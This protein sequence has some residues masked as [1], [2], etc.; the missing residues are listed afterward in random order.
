MSLIEQD[1]LSILM[2]EDDAHDE[3]LVVSTLAREGLLFTHSRVVNAE[4]FQAL[5]DQDDWDLI[6]SDYNLPIFS[7]EEVLEILRERGLDIPC[8][9]ISGYIGE[10]AAVSLMKAGA[11]DFVPKGNLSR[12][13]PAIR[14][15]VAE[16]RNRREKRY[17]EQT[18]HR[19]EKLIVGIA[20]AL[21]E[22]LAVTDELGG[23][24]FINPEAER[25]LGWSRYEIAGKNL[26]QVAH[27][28]KEDGTPYPEEQCPIANYTRKG[29]PYRSED[30]VF[31]RKDGTTFHVSYVATPIVEDGK[32]VA[33]VTAFQN[34]SRRKQAEREL[35]E[36]RRTLR[37]L[38]NF[39]QTVR[40]EERTRIAR[41]LHDELGQALT[42]LKMDIAWMLSRFADGQDDLLTKAD[43]M[44]TLID[45]TV[46]SVRR[47]A[48]NL[49]PGLLDDLGLAAAVEWLLDEFQQ[50][51]QVSY[52]LQMSHDEVD[53]ESVLNTTVF[54]ILQEAITNVARYAQATQLFVELEDLGDSLVLSVKDD[55]VG[56]DPQGVAGK[57]KSFGLL[58][59][60]ERVSSLGGRFEI[61]SQPGRGTELKV[62]LPK[63]YSQHTSWET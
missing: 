47:I 41:E 13:L 48:A 23:I 49:R 43:S 15:E 54:R 26:H 60:R 9:V 59:I 24:V 39:L 6:L 55:G 30:E 18:L 52:T 35:T 27:Y 36:S 40:E 5:L 46:D 12:L 50:R 10:E 63:T 34:I 38:S 53:F 20:E 16:A 31:V 4:N 37:G 61:V 42:A 25:L 17:V 22:G 51:T 19:K 14:R 45:S 8:I 11:C 62:S 32:V 1:K 57:R 58:G 7:G 2:V 28:L 21:G 3:A 29:E 56:F 44:M 33:V